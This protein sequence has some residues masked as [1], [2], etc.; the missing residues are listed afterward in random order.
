MIN[1]SSSGKQLQHRGSQAE[2]SPAFLSSC[3][4]RMTRP[5]KPRVPARP[6]LFPTT[7]RFTSNSHSSQLIGNDVAAILG[8]S[9]PL[10]LDQRFILINGK[11]TAPS[12]IFR[13]SFGEAVVT[14]IDSDTGI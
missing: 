9:R 1:D 2:V 12:G 11:N 4:V 13:N 7:Q 6:A 3:E 8:A 10:S 14:K 5:P